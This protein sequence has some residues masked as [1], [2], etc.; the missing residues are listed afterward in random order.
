MSDEDY[1]VYARNILTRLD[2]IANPTTRF[3][4]DIVRQSSNG[5]GNGAWND[6]NMGLAVMMVVIA[7]FL[8]MALMKKKQTKPVSKLD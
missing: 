1:C 6:A 3:T 2:S 7:A 4:S 5:S 8:I